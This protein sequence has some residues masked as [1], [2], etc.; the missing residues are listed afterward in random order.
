MEE[1]SVLMSVYA[2]EK[3]EFL[4]ESMESMF[5]QTVPTNDFVLVCDGPL[6]DELN[7][8]IDEMQKLH[9]EI[10]HI[11]RLKENMGL[12]NAL[13]AGLQCCR[14]ELVARM[15][16]DDISL[17]HRCELQLRAFA[18]DRTLVI[19]SGTIAEFSQKPE[20]IVGIKKVP[21]T[22]Q[23]ILSFSK[24]RN[25]FNHPAVMVKKT[26]VINVGGYDEVYHLFEDYYLWIRMLMDGCKA[27]NITD[28]V[29]L[30]RTPEDLYLRRGGMA[31]AKNMLRFHRWMKMCGWTNWND[32]LAGA[33]LHAAVCI[34]PN[35]IRK[36]CY[37]Y[38]RKLP[39]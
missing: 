25:P 21:E 28:T 23:E 24:R 8:V 34:M 2:K 15:D 35:Y 3:P 20:N 9:P 30:M 6:T 32:Y 12:G 36:Y 10:L 17:P 39:I 5:A 38:L 27:K 31:Y 4:R 16:S 19:L 26:A 37:L 33:V 29:L 14:H 13:N 22:H 18:A 7:A 11:V 1:Y